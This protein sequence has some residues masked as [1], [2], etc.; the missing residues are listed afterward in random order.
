MQDLATVCKR[1]R[2][3][4]G[5]LSMLQMQNLE[6]GN[7]GIRTLSSSI[8]S[9]THLVVLWLQHNLISSKAAMALSRVLEASPHVLYLFL[10]DNSLSNEGIA[11]IAPQLA[12][13]QVCHLDYNNI[14]TTGIKAL[15]NQ[16]RRP[17]CRLETLMLD[18]NPID[19]EGAKILSDAL[20]ENTSLRRLSLRRIHFSTKGLQ[21]IR[22]AL[23]QS[24]QT[25][26]DLKID[27]VCSFLC[28]PQ[29]CCCPGCALHED[30]QFFTTWN[31][32]GRRIFGNFQVNNKLW[33]WILARANQSSDSICFRLLT[34]RPDIVG[35][36]ESTDT[37]PGMDDQGSEQSVKLNDM[38]IETKL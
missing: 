36:S 4:D 10:G 35:T 15:A 28:P 24:N 1:L 21:F 23:S 30:I 16:L 38:D 31:R 37:Q 19:E 5:T 33:P 34:T 32:G 14:G 9:P 17:D 29:H 6:L 13:L 25:L 2:S 12:K 3:D 7:G 20:E 26:V 18:G 27:S 11:T 22:N 8:V